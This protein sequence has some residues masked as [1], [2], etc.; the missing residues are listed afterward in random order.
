M[1]HIKQCIDQ[2]SPRN[3]MAHIGMVSAMHAKWVSNEPPYMPATLCAPHG[4][5]RKRDDFT[6]LAWTSKLMRALLPK[7]ESGMPTRGE[8][9]PSGCHVSNKQGAKQGPAD[10]MSP[11]W[12]LLHEGQWPGSAGTPPPAAALRS[13]SGMRRPHAVQL[14]PSPRVPAFRGAAA[15]AH[16]AARARGA[17]GAGSQAW[18]PRPAP[19]P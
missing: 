7:Y 8:Y 17:T 9:C 18:V 1:R 15:L 3:G 6:L 10:P 13:A 2:A 11:K 16:A 14:A 12:M 19:G 4:P 5:L